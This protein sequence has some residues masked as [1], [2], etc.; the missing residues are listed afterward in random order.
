M[1][2]RCMARRTGCIL[3]SCVPPGNCCC[4]GGHIGEA[5]I[6]FMLNTLTISVALVEGSGRWQE[7]PPGRLLPK[8]L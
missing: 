5:T 1:R 6:A 4:F 7:R 2:W 8:V 3:Q